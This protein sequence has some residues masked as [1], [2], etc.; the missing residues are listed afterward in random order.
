MTGIR[1]GIISI[2]KAVMPVFVLAFLTTSLSGCSDFKKVIGIE[3]TSPD[4]FAVESRAPLTIPPDFDLRPPAPGSGRPQEVSAANKAK[5]AIDNAAP[6]DPGKQAT[7]TLHYPGPQADPDSQVA[8]QSL[9]AK[10]L[11]SGD[12]GDSVVVEKRETTPL[13]GVY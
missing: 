7:G 13:K 4:E 12:T 3:K 6:G 9:A 5:T 2:S 11:Q 1:R 10:L 8:D